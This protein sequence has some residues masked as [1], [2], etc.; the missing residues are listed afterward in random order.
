RISAGRWRWE[1]RMSGKHVIRQLSAYHHQEVNASEKRNIEAHLL[2]CL[3]CRDAYNEIRLGA[4][5]ASSLKVSPAPESVWNGLSVTGR[6]P[7]RGRWIPLAALAALAATVLLV[8]IHMWARPSWEVTG[9]PGTTQLHPGEILQTS[10]TSEAQ[11]KIA[12]IGNLF[13]GPN[14][15]IRLLVTKSDQHRIALDR[16]RIEAQTWSPPR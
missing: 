4:R 14:S 16:G 6:A 7:S 3:R 9:L 10:S 1:S 5:L 12:N 13:V 2:T 11:I 15:Q 8:A